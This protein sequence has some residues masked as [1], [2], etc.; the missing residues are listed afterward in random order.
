ML[1]QSKKVGCVRTF[2]YEKCQMSSLGI[3]LS[4]DLHSKSSLCK[5][6]ICNWWSVAE[7]CNSELESGC[8]WGGPNATMEWENLNTNWATTPFQ[9][10]TRFLFCKGGGFTKKISFYITSKIVN[11]LG[12]MYKLGSNIHGELGQLSNTQ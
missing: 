5:S 10:T 9:S 2:W 11:F 1:E 4:G 8:C 12:F 6:R 3:T 7:C